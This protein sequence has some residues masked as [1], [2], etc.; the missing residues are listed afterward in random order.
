MKENEMITV[1]CITFKIILVSGSSPS[2]RVQQTPAD[3]YMKPTEK[4]Q[5]NCSHSILNYDRILWYKQT[6]NN[7]QLQLLGYMW[8]S[9]G[10]PEK[11]A[12]VT[13]DGGANKDETCTLTTE[14]LGLNSSSVFFC[15]ASLHSS[16][17]SHKV[18]QTPANMYKK[19]AE[20]AKIQCS[21][22]IDNYNQILWYKQTQN[23][24]QLQLLGYMV[25]V[26]VDQ[27]PAALIRKA[28][29]AVQLVCTH[30]EADY[31]VMLWYRQSPGDQALKL[32]GHI[33][34]HL[35]D[36]E[37]AFIKH[38][39]LAG[40]LSGDGK[41]GSLSIINLK[42]PKHTATYFCA[43]SEPQYVNLP[44]ALYKNLF[45]LFSSGSVYLSKEKQVFQTPAELLQKAN[46]EVKLSL[47][48]QIQS[49]DTILWY[50]RSAGDNSLKLIGYV[51]YKNPTVET[52]FQSHFKVSGDGEDTAFLHI[53]N[54]THPEDSGEYFGAASMHSSKDERLGRTKTS[55]MMMRQITAQRQETTETRRRGVSQSVLI[56]QW[57]HYI[58]RLPSGS[59]EM[60]CYQNDTDYDYMYWYRQLRGGEIQL[61]GYLVAGSANYEAGFQSGFEAAK[62][63][64]KQ[65]SLKI[66]SVQ[67]E[68]EAVYLCAASLHSAVTD[69]RSVTKTSS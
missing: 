16:S 42:A 5:I 1:F 46:G 4:A 44:S 12:G 35:H 39:K 51:A 69:T 32:I 23:N 49:Y 9:G 28:G 63:Q 47:T 10:S 48:H 2:H 18:K 7:G 62:S 65:W 13:I 20:M 6:Q 41:N 30:G 25:G 14:A 40:D 27:S 8:G 54:L 57:P 52:P 36:V 3:M 43:A 64:E 66:A 22:S 61:V 21:H 58:S 34:S 50:R 56:T 68:D 37:G 45:P 19:P 24:G 53:F 31:N 67:R 60:S 59:A 55:V 33:Y 29:D 26:Q 15:A 38:F 17:P 11:G